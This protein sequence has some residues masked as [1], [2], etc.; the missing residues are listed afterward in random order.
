[1]Y[2]ELEG[3]VTT[4]AAHF[5]NLR[6]LCE[7]LKRTGAGDGIVVTPEGPLRSLNKA[8]PGSGIG[9]TRFRIWPKMA[10]G[11]PDWHPA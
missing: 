2:S 9:T 5:I 7:I 10:S 3:S 4:S 11:R 6:F 1:M 8:T